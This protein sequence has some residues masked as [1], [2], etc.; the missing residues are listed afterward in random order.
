MGNRVMLLGLADNRRPAVPLGQIVFVAADVYVDTFTSKWQ[1]V[2]AEGVLPATSYISGR[3]L[4]LWISYSLHRAERTGFVRKTPF[5]APSL[6][7]VDA[8]AVDTSLIGHGYFASE[9]SLLTDL[10]LLVRKGLSPLERGLQSDRV[11][12][13][14]MFPR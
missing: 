5:L 8:T 2:L 6:D 13:C 10:G 12:K 7:T 9:R 3:D 11:R 4:A 14:W 1:K